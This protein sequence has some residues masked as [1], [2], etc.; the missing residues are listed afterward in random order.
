MVNGSRE[1][2][3]ERLGKIDLAPNRFVDDRQVR[4]VI[5]R[6]LAPLGRRI[7]ESSPMVDARLP[8]G[9]RVNATIPPHVDR[10]AH[11]DHSAL[12]KN[13]PYVR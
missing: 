9:S 4:L 10:W 2:F 3:V 1:V 13:A 8:D 6:I 7:D 5:E 11:A 12:R